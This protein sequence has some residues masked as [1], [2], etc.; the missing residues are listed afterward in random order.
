[1]SIAALACMSCSKPTDMMPINQNP[2]ENQADTLAYRWKLL[3]T[4]DSLVK[5]SMEP[6]VFGNNV[7]FSEHDIFVSEPIKMFDGNTGEL[8]WKWEDYFDQSQ[9]LTSYNGFQI[10]GDNAY[11][12]ASFRELY[13]IDLNTGQTNWSYKEDSDGAGPYFRIV[14]DYLYYEIGQEPDRPTPF[15][16]IVHLVRTPLGGVTWDT[17]FTVVEGGSTIPRLLMPDVHFNANGDEI[18]TFIY[19][20]SDI[21]ATAGE[22]YLIS[23]NVTQDT[24]IYQTGSW[25]GLGAIYP[26]VIDGDKLYVASAKRFFCFDLVTGIPIW[27]MDFEGGTDHMLSGRYL[28]IDDKVILKD[29]AKDL[30]AL[31]KESGTVIWHNPNAGSVPSDIVYH[32]EYLYYTSGDGHLYA[33][34]EETGETI[35]KERSPHE[36]GDFSLTG[37]AI[38]EDLGLLY[39]SDKFYV[40]AFEV[41]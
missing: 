33:F 16:S 20:R 41:L 2:N 26:P 34:E 9:D 4:E 25:D 15:D 37:V 8:V 30:Y 5:A 22:V 17:I 29:T 32:N 39:T 3:L 14:N 21:D 18:A 12:C 23:I 10:K 31:D 28:V 7:L 38:N 40:Y 6:R 35:W 24:V 36:N 11:L 1:M 27:Q 19:D 13:S